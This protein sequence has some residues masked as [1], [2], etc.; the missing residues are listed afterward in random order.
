MS[1]FRWHI[2]R[3]LFGTLFMATVLTLAAFVAWQFV[4]NERAVIEVGGSRLTVEVARTELQR[5]RGLAGHAP[6]GAAQGM[7]FLFDRPD[8]YSFW[9]RGMEFPIDIIWIR[10]GRIVH[11]EERLPV[12]V[13]GGELPSYTPLAE[14]DAVLEVRAGFSA[15]HRLEVGNLVTSPFN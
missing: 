10:D 3:G 2:F 15:E 9:M 13:K 7:L 8:R 5:A 14:A 1:V 6:L 4:S 12:P 11:I